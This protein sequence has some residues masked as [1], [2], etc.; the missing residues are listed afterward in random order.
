MRLARI[1]RRHLV[2]IGVLVA[3]LVGVA[4][5]LHSLWIWRGFTEYRMERERDIRTPP[6]DSLRPI[7]GLRENLV[8]PTGKA[9]SAPRC[10]E[11]SRQR[12]GHPWPRRYR[13]RRKGT[14]TA[15]AA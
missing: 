10:H 11:L 12:S 14:R 5:W 2:A 8:S 13:W 9:G 7:P 15:R 4:L 1:R 6:N 3:T